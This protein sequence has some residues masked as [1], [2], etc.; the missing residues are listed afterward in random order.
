MADCKHR[1]H[2][3]WATLLLPRQWSFLVLLLVFL[4]LSYSVTG[5][6]SSWTALW[7]LICDVCCGHKNTELAGT[8]ESI[9][10][11][12]GCRY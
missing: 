10:S 8:L 2:G 6:D 5:T 12:I 9:W 3:F 4:C 11:S 1:Q 7:C